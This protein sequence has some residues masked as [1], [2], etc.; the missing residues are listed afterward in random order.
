MHHLHRPVPCS[1]LHLLLLVMVALVA[2]PLHAGVPAVANITITDVTT[3]SFSVV[4]QA[5]E[6]STAFLRVFTNA[7]GTI[8]ALRRSL[9][10][11][12]LQ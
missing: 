10:P 8:S 9:R 6:A 5:S 11:I 3:R 1:V 7:T 2:A 4:W 12:Q